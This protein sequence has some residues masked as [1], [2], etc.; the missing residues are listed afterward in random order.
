MRRARSGTAGGFFRWVDVEV[1]PVPAVLSAQARTS[2]I[3]WR[4][5]GRNPGAMPLLQQS[6]HA[7]LERDAELAES[8]ARRQAMLVLV[9]SAAMA[10]R[11]VVALRASHL[12]G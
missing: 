8:L 11:R 10:R 1:D 4:W 5:I 7:R 9:E 6:L 12:A 3:L 2:S